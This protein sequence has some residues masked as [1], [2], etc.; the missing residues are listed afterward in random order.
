M[1]NAS[2]DGKH[3]FAFLPVGFSMFDVFSDGSALLL[4]HTGP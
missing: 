4:H 2:L 1:L 3:V